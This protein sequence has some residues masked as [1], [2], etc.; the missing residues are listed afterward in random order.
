MRN[1]L[2]QVIRFRSGDVVYP[3]GVAAPA[4][5]TS[6]PATV[7]RDASH[8]T[9]EVN[10]LRGGCSLAWTRQ[11]PIYSHPQLGEGSGSGYL[12]WTNL[13]CSSSDVSL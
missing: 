13:S 3:A 10:T 6:P 9:A 11:E 12:K 4:G 1:R 7:L 8:G 2:R 5:D